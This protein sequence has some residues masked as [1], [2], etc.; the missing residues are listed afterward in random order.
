MSTGKYDEKL[1]Q[2]ST[3]EFDPQEEQQLL[4]GTKVE[5]K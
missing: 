4:A 1:H 2:L 3:G 5:K